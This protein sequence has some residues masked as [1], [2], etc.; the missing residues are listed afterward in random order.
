MTGSIEYGV[1]DLSAATADGEGARAA[2]AAGTSRDHAG[3]ARVAAGS[4][5][6]SRAHAAPPASSIAVHN[7]MVGNKRANTK[8]ELLMRRRLREAGLVGYR[9]QWKV[10]GRPDIA[11]PGKKVALFVH[12]CFW[13][14]HKGCKH[15][16]MPKSHVEYWL[17]KFD[18]NVERDERSVAELI[19]RGW[20]VH[21][22]WEC[23]LKKTTI[24][25]TLATLLPE[26][27]RELNKPLVP[28]GPGY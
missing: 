10:P 23:E 6:A 22:V 11:W 9:L 27:A 24:G 14:R 3:E 21:V 7:A 20:K 4:R 16:T 13:H 19:S 8:P 12:G 15:A 2:K 17:V 1:V 5:G 28:L 25:P 18:R 26:L